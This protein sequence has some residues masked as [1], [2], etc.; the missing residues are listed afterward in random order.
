MDNGGGDGFE[1]DSD[2]LREFLVAREHTLACF[3]YVA[4]DKNYEFNGEDSAP[5][6]T[7]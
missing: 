2:L 3:R 1:S 5:Y 6:I 7:S 4:L